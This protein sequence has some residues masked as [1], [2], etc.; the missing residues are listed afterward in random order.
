MTSI[1]LSQLRKD[2]GDTINRTRYTKERFAVKSRG[3]PVAAIVSIEDLDLLRAIEDHMD[4]AA[5]L[6][7]LRDGEFVSWDEAEAQL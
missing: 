5:A 7:A 3:R 4:T 6:K 2:L 1:A